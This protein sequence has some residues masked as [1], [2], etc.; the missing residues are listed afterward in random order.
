MLFGTGLY[1]QSRHTRVCDND[2]QGW[3]DTDEDDVGSVCACELKSQ[4]QRQAAS[5]A[6]I[7]RRVSIFWNF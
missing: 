6:I 1:L 5:D 2:D 4:R 3:V 7:G